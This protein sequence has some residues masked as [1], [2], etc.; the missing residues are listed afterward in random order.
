MAM[1]TYDQVMNAKD[2][3][4]GYSHEIRNLEKVN[5]AWKIFLVSA[6]MYKGK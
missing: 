1:V 6:H 5:G 4:K 2:G 3:I